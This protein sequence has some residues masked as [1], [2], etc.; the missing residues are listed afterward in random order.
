MVCFGGQMVELRAAQYVTL[1]NTENVIAVP[2]SPMSAMTATVDRLR[3]WAPCCAEL[4][5]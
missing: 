3:T 4:Q 1:K 2:R 5:P